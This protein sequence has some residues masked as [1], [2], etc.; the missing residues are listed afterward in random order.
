M[1]YSGLRFASGQHGPV[2]QR[3]TNRGPRSNVS[4]TWR[5]FPGPADLPVRGAVDVERDG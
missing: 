1:K 4:S 3:E 2:D 5:G